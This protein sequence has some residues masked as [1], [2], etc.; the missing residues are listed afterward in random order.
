MSGH[1]I[2]NQASN[3]PVDLESGAVSGLLGLI[4][5]LKWTSEFLRTD[6][7][8]IDFDEF[9]QG[10]LDSS[11]SN[12][13]QQVI[14]V[15][16]F[17]DEIQPVGNLV[18]S[19]LEE[20]TDSSSPQKLTR[21]KGDDFDRGAENC[22]PVAGLDSCAAELYKG[23]IFK[24]CNLKEVRVWLHEFA[25]RGKFTIGTA[26][27][28]VVT[29]KPRSSRLL[30]MRCSRA[31]NSKK[32]LQQKSV[33]E[34]KRAAEDDD[35]VLK[36]PVKK[37]H[38]STVKCGCDW[39]VEVRHMPEK[40]HCQLT[41]LNLNHTNGCAPSDDGAAFIRCKRGENMLKIPTHLAVTLQVLFN[42][43]AK[44]S[45]IRKVLREHKVVPD[46]EPISAQTLVNL[47]LKLDR[48]GSD[49]TKYR[50]VH[51]TVQKDG[52]LPGITEEESTT[53]DRF[54]RE[55]LKENLNADKSAKIINILKQLKTKYPG[56][57]YRIATDCHNVLTAWMFLTAEMRTLA[58]L[59]GQVLFLDAKLSGV[60]VVDWPYFGFGVVD[61]ENHQHIICHG[62]TFSESN[63]AYGWMLKATT[64]IV[65]ALKNI[66]RLTFSDQLV[67]ERIL[68]SVLSSL[69]V[70]ALCNFHLRE[71]NLPQWAKNPAIL[72][73]VK[74]DFRNLQEKDVSFQEWEE[75]LKHFK[76]TWP[77]GPTRFVESIQHEKHRW[78][79][80]WTH[81][82][83]NVF[84]NGN[85]ISEIGYSSV[86]AWLTDCED[87]ANLIASFVSY[88]A[89]RNNKHRR[90]LTKLQFGLARKIDETRHPALKKC[91]RTFS[92]FITDKFEEQLEL[93]THYIASPI[94]EADFNSW[95][96]SHEDFPNKQR[97]VTMYP[98]TKL[99]SC[100]C[101]T[102]P[103]FGLPCRHIQCVLDL[104]GMDL[105]DE[106]YFHKRW[107][108]RFE[109]I[110][111]PPLSS[112]TI[113]HIQCEPA[114]N[115]NRHDI[116]VFESTNE[117]YV[118]EDERAQSST[119]NSGQFHKRPKVSKP[120]LRFKELMA[121]SK[122]LCGLAAKDQQLTDF[123]LQMLK[124]AVNSLRC[125]KM[126]EM[127]LDG[128]QTSNP[129]GLSNEN[130]P[131]AVM[132]P[133]NAQCGPKIT[134]RFLSS[135]ESLK[136]KGRPKSHSKKGASA[137]APIP[138]L[139]S[140]CSNA[141]CSKRA[142]KEVCKYGRLAN[143]ETTKWVSDMHIPHVSCI[144]KEDYTHNTFPPEWQHVIL[145]TIYKDAQGY[146][147]V[148]ITTMDKE[149]QV[150]KQPM[151]YT[152][153][154]FQT[155]LLTKSI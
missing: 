57:E 46:T 80:P 81:R 112:T 73:S 33:G 128:T 39:F 67:S 135:G 36:A 126:P 17:P 7:F 30:L 15:D 63:D 117:N 152:F 120:Q 131:P 2:S 83:L 137:P 88:D 75:N 129:F 143:P 132:Y 28:S 98:Q 115:N 56:F 1:S 119:S 23:K 140:I 154:A 95:A 72:D 90:R 50:D 19:F 130:E 109:L 125:N 92:E 99:L 76:Q 9:E 49:L 60:S 144:N 55:W 44:A 133:L 86:A 138:A 48:V 32:Q 79:A 121:E 53:I 10:C 87:H 64:D 18:E 29:D 97:I 61:E 102:T 107:A 110:P 40:E 155:W 103:A 84:K 149:L 12:N 147:Y 142:C 62:L 85:T 100:N 47:K 146:K 69:E 3:I 37:R 77:G 34:T 116:D 136:K 68:F 4:G 111:A 94:L 35:F 59:Y 150:T 139:C 66:T 105:F 42:S 148:S 74:K 38:S 122:V 118:G 24:T 31:G 45:A 26:P 101:F 127:I 5:S 11:G 41:D 20:A 27:G 52:T 16:E 104:L 151:L 82:V 54:A 8:D 13:N 89:E 108:R 96:V 70:A 123:V 71:F 78:A 21:N 51:F 106:R 134:K 22:E 58:E 65:P 91:L 113:A 145:N 114:E 14:D 6:D 153:V 43:K 124:T 141:G 25:R 93:G